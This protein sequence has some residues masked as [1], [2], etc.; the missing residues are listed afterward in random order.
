ME[1]EVTNDNNLA[2]DATNSPESGADGLPNEPS[3]QGEA[4]QAGETSAVVPQPDLPN[5]VKVDEVPPSLTA[6]QQRFYSGYRQAMIAWVETHKNT[7]FPIIDDPITGQPRWRNRA[8]R[9]RWQK[10]HGPKV[11][12]RVHNYK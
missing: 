2:P 11:Q 9:R 6:D 5:E 12:V 7:N 4:V 3:Q 1:N 8:E 10:K